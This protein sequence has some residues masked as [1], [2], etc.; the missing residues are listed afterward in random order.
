M[1]V[2]SAFAV[3]GV[4]ISALSAAGGDGAT[5]EPGRESNASTRSTSLT[6]RRRVTPILISCSTVAAGEAPS[7][8]GLPHLQPSDRANPSKLLMHAST[9][10]ET[11]WHVLGVSKSRDSSAENREP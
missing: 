2:Y 4:S 1:L 11:F 7:Q 6:A 10:M 8:D 3:T 5:G 9:Y